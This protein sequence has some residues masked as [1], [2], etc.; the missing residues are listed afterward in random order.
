VT[1]QTAELMQ[2]ARLRAEPGFTSVNGTKTAYWRY[3]ATS[4]KSMGQIIFVHGYRGN[5]HGLEA[6]AGA[7]ENYEL[8][9]PDLPGFGQS[10]TLS[11]LH[12]IA[13]YAVWL[14]GFVSALKIEH[15]I[16]LAHS[17]GTLVASASVASDLDAR[18]LI[19]LNPVAAQADKNR[20][21]I[22]AIQMWIVNA[23]LKIT[24]ALPERLGLALLRNPL[25]VLLLS[26]VMAKTKDR[27]LR[28]FI[29]RQHW[30]NFSDF[31][32]RRVAIEGY[33]ASVSMTV[34]QFA[35]KIEQPTLLI[36]GRLDDVTPLPAQEKLTNLF[37]D[38][39]MVVIDGLGHLTHYEVPAKTG[40]LVK[41]FLANLS[42]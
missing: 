8:I 31:K 5:H 6:I 21:G 14:A 25:P 7:I 12:S 39:K 36:A 10:D 4:A 17:F 2:L 3:P 23:F 15:P 26:A 20:V 18:A 32:D 38:C 11:Q 9:I 22:T 19:L 35:K 33:E 24:R 37:C 30:D 29:H 13:N 40:E 41:E 34:T 27:E 1:N 42:K 28:N 16:V